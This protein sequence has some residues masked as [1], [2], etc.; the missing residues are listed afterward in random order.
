MKNFLALLTAYALTAISFVSLANNGKVDGIVFFANK[1]VEAATVN[2][3]NA[4]DSTVMKTVLSSKTGE[5]EVEKI[6]DGKY[7]ISVSAVGYNKYYSQ[8]FQITSTSPAYSLK[9]IELSA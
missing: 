7:L 5:F 1:P 3:L 6:S 4:T 2:L 8:P 9:T